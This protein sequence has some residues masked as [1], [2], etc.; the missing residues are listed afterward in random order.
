MHCLVRIL[1]LF[2]ALALS[3]CA[4]QGGQ[5]KIAS[6]GERPAPVILV[7]LDGFRADY[8]ELH[9]PPTLLALAESGLRAEALRPSTPTVTFPNHYT[10]VTGLHP[11]RHGIVGNRMTDAA[12]PGEVFTMQSKDRFWWDGAEPLWVTAE[13]ANL[14]AATLFW[15]GSESDVRGVR[16]SF[17]LPYNKDMPYEERVDQVLAWLEQP[18]PPRFITLYFEAVDSAGHEF[19]PEA[20]ETTAAVAKVDAALARLRKGLARQG[21]EANLVVVSDHG[22]AQTSP[23]RLLY[24]DDMLDLA[25]VQVESTG[26]LALLRPQP[27]R[28]AEVEAALLGARAHMQC[29]RKGETPARLRYGGHPRIP[30]IVCE[31][32]TGWV[33]G[34]RGQ[35]DPTRLR[36]GTHGYDRAS[37]EMAALFVAAGP[38]FRRGVVIEEAES[39]DVQPLLGRLLGLAV[40]PG[41][42]DAAVF[43]PGLTNA[44]ARTQ[45]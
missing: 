36:G 27:G 29:W 6:V 1:L 24:L 15:P 38:A 13:N 10:L 9:R 44:Q 12:R 39:V 17:W 45:H 21:V 37:P 23:E 25:A 16:P 41:D 2:G 31:A 22:M 11:D 3:A 8:L 5:A 43:A 28:E 30:P 40:P 14:R 19:G 7:S 34:M 18:E 32:E 42:G 26:A 20:G 33:M 35:T 4:H